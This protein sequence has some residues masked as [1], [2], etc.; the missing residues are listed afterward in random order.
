MAYKV[1]KSRSPTTRAPPLSPDRRDAVSALVLDVDHALDGTV[2]GLSG[3]FVV[4]IQVG[5]TPIYAAVE[6]GGLPVLHGRARVNTQG[7]SEEGV[8]GNDDDV[9]THAEMLDGRS[10]YGSRL[11]THA[12]R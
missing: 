10:Q 3:I 4:A 2:L 9:G 8:A 7:H 1:G 12:G 6:I 5:L 11:G